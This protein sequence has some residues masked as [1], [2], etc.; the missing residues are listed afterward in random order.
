MLNDRVE[1]TPVAGRATVAERIKHLILERQMRPGEPLPTEGELCAAVGASRST[2]REAIKMLRAL[3]IVEVR[4]GYGSY[5]GHM[6]LN[7][8]VESLAF[9]GLL[10]SSDDHQVLA[11]LIA[12]QQALAQG[13]AGQLL[14]R[15]TSE[16]REKLTRITSQMYTKAARGEQFVEEDRTFHLAL[17]EPLENDLVLQLTAAFWE[18]Q[19]I[20]A[21]RLAPTAADAMATADLHVGIVDSLAT[22]DVIQVQNAIAAHYDPVRELLGALPIAASLADWPDVATR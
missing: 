14:N 16:R 6:S 3:D 20:I 22:G 7:A 2:V 15:A 8:L 18:V 17:M 5:V 19:A 9:R 13:F 11:N 4:H 21:P 1:T 12:V 10:R